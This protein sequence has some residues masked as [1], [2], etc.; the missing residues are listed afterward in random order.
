MF[1]NYILIDFENI[2]PDNLEII[3][4]LNFKIIIFVGS[5]QK[6]IS[7]E[8]VDIIQSFGNNAEYVKIEGNGQNALD[9]H[10]AFYIGKISALEKE[11][12]FHIISKDT[13]FDPLVNHLK[14]KKIKVQRVKNIAEIP[15]IQNL[16]NKAIPV[17]SITKTLPPKII[18]N[19][20]TPIKK[21]ISKLPNYD[22]NIDK[23][24]KFLKQKKAARPGTKKTLINSIN[25]DLFQKKL[26]EKEIENLFDEIL[27]RE[28][29]SMN[30]TKVN[31]S[32]PGE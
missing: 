28:Y 25:N 3:K 6:K 27:K 13:G 17:P 30:N 19:K 11:A 24:I 2:Q 16:M 14:L 21:A 22:E 20:V 4:N 15:M 10:I 5:N 29:I 31:Y 18:E 26:T 23:I 8:M 12:F 7:F 9:F 1:I 32:L